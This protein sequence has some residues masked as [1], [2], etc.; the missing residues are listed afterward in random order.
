MGFLHEGH[1]SLVRKSKAST[2]VTVVSIFVNPTQF[3]PNEDLE[4]YPRDIEQDKSLLLKE[5]VDIIF[6]PSAKDIYPYDFQTYISV[7]KITQ[8]LEGESRPTHFKGV[9]TVVNIL[10]NLVTP[11]IAFFGQKD[12]QQAAVI[13]QMVKDLK[14]P[15]K[16]EVCPIVREPDGLAMSSRNVYLSADE[17]KD[18]LVLYS[19]LLKGKKLIFEGETEP[20]VVIDNMTNRFSNIASAQLEYIKIVEE[21]TFEIP[22]FL[23]NNN[24]YLLLVACRMGKTRL[25]DNIKVELH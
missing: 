19:S 25:I 11:D 12:A 6:I 21:N 23:E 10:F 14:L 22:L 5:G 20:Q 1:L 16:I 4:K 7:E 24:N 13:K 18:A 15:I 2:D 3:A 8:T 9:T 17:R